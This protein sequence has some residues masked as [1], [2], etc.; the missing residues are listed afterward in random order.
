MF[1][2]KRSLWIPTIAVFAVVL[3]GCIPILPTS[4]LAPLAGSPR[5]F[6][7]DLIAAFVTRDY[8]ALESMM[9]DPFV[10]ALWQSEG[11]EIAPTT[12]VQQLRDDI[13]GPAT[14]LTFVSGEILQRWLGGA[15]PLALWPPQV[16]VIDAAGVTGL[17]A[18]GSG[19]AI[20][21][22]AEDDAGDSY[23]YAMLL[24]RDGFVPP[25]GEQYA[26]IVIHP[27]Q[28]PMTILPADAQQVL[29]LGP[30]GIFDG[31]DASFSQ[32]GVTQRGQTYPVLGVSAD[33]QWWAVRCSQSAAPCWIGANPTFVRPVKLPAASGPAVAPPPPTATPQPPAYPTRINFAPGQTSAIVRGYVGPYDRPQYIFYA[34]AGQDAR[35]VID[36][37]S[38]TTSFAVRGV[39]DGVLYKSLADPARQFALTLPRTQDYLITVAASVNTSFIVELF[40]SPLPT[41]P[42]SPER[43]SFGPGEEMAVRS[44]NTGASGT[45]QYIFRA[46]SGQ[47]GRIRL[48]S[49]GAAANF[50]LRG[51]ADGIEYKPLSNPARDVSFILP[52]TQDYLITISGPANLDFL[53]EL[54]IKPL[55]PPPPLPE[56]IRFGPG[57]DSAVRSGPLY[58][59]TPKQYIFGAQA[60]Q[61]TRIR[62]GSPSPA[63]RFSVQGASDGIIYKS[64]GDASTEWNYTL[65]RTQDYV[66]TIQAPVNT[67]YTVELYIEPLATPTSTPTKTA[68]PTMT[69]TATKTA[70]GVP[71]A[72]STQTS[73]PTPT[74]TV[75]PTPTSSSTATTTATP[76]PTLTATPSPTSSPTA[77]ASETPTPTLTATPSPTSTPTATASETPTATLTATATATPTVT[78]TETPTETATATETPTAT[79]TET[80]TP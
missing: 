70:T 12:A 68:T 65:P 13:L 27:A 6:S 49:P 15:D 22:V 28:P 63:A 19:Q 64:M 23:W 37:P 71:T 78:A 48:E 17:G 18:D 42:P 66:M 54:S 62:L 47:E 3:A 4:R 55:G 73:T 60:T 5:Q 58:A 43:I 7:S 16:V 26:P 41:P 67:S 38:P 29:I 56:R 25:A 77:T 24:A 9:G 2:V 45:K 30:L 52:R 57:Q 39:A 51:V 72:T 79:P 31:P 50:A 21:I 1:S 40:V 61:N 74:M 32:I 76:T 34:F 35:V 36:S 11:Q 44:G 75:T 80:P 53:L 59:N 20:L 10:L 33:G 14:S 46:F 8:A 69:A